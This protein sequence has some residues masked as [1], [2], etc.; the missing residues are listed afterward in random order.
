MNRHKSKISVF[1]ADRSKP[2]HKGFLFVQGLPLT[3]KAAF[4]AA[5]A[6]RGK[7]M[8]DVIIELMRGYSERDAQNDTR[9]YYRRLERCRK[10]ST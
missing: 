4:K 7:S 1:P 6:A 3:T 9:N 8:R 2:H 5:C 10:Q